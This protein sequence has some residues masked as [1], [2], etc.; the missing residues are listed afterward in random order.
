MKRPS[1]YGRL[2][3][4]LS[5]Q[6]FRAETATVNPCHGSAA[7]IRTDAIRAST[8]GTAAP[9]FPYTSFRF[10]PVNSPHPFK[11]RLHRK[12]R[13]GG[14]EQ[15][16]KHLHAALPRR[17]PETPCALFRVHLPNRFSFRNSRPL[18]LPPGNSTLRR[19]DPSDRNKKDASTHFL[20]H[21]LLY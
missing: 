18:P 6:N 12:G 2:C 17:F 5:S 20:L 11:G 10:L 16:E 4:A 1:P 8:R 14:A 13:T 3:K 7:R 9:S 15:R 19:P 21:R